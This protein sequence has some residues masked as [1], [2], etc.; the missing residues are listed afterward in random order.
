MPQI[1]A[2]QPLDGRR[3]WLVAAWAVRIWGMVSKREKAMREQVVALVA[4][5]LG[6]PIDRVTDR[7][8]HLDGIA[9]AVLYGTTALGFCWLEDRGYAVAICRAYNK[10]SADYYSV[11]RGTIPSGI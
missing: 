4:E 6:V 5:Q 11:D 10:W 8:S 9:M 2:G 7:M 3:I 1:V